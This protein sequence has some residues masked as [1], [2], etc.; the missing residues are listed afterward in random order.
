MEEWW[1]TCG[2][3]ALQPEV[4]QIGRIYMGPGF[5]AKTV[6]EVLSVVFLPVEGPGQT[7]MLLFVDVEKLDGPLPTREPR[8]LVFESRE[9]G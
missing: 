7:T 6:E 5:E 1:R 9:S 2:P 4:I 8:V 3:V